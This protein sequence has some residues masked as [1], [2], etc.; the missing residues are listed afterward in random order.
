LNI[1]E[2]IASGVLEEYVLGLTTEEKSN[3]IVEL[4]AKHEEIQ[5]E[6]S[7]IEE[8]VA[9]YSS[10][11]TKDPPKDLK[12][13]ILSAIVQEALPVP[14][15]TGQSKIEDYAHWLNSV[16]APDAYENVHMEV[17]YNSK[18]AT[19]VIAWIKEGELNHDHQ[20]Y[21]ERFLIVEGSCV[22]TIGG[23]TTTYEIGDFVEF[24]VD[25]E[26][27]YTVTSDIPMKVVACLDHKLSS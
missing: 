26:H 13:N 9:V 22:A 23:E 16:K 3:E 21:T 20:E 7:A 24:P 27:S 15:L 12:A 11:F 25:I 2:Y 14:P 17:I 5:L 10:A 1:K 6:I 19:I 18:E 4:A 8:S